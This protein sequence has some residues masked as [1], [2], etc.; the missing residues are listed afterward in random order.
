RSHQRPLTRRPAWPVRWASPADYFLTS[1][2]VIP[3]ATD[4]YF[5]PLGNSTRTTAFPGRASLGTLTGPWWS[6]PQQRS[7]SSQTRRFSLPIASREK[8]EM[9][10]G[11][12]SLPIAEALRA[13]RPAQHP[14]SGP[15]GYTGYLH[16]LPG[17]RR[18]PRIPQ[19]L[20]W[21]LSPT[22]L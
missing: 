20:A 18:Q 7:F 21:I 13:R 1:S 5:E 17:P 4:V 15:R 12:V 3:V 6:M 9:P 19:G 2:T 10:T 11:D 22:P 16:G 8:L 14:G